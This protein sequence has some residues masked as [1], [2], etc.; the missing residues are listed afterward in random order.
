M[1]KKRIGDLLIEAGI[2]S[3]EQLKRALELQKQSGDRLGRI[4]ID[5]NFVSE[6]QI[7][8]VLE[9]QLGIPF[10]DLNEIEIPPDVQRL[11]PFQL[12]YRHNVVPVKVERTLL[13]VAMEDPLNFIAIEDLR[14]ATNYEIVPVISFSDAIKRTINRLYGSQTADK[15]IQEFQQEKEKSSISS[16]NLQNISS[17]EVDSAPIVRLV[18]STI[19]QAALSGASDIHIEPLENE[20]RV[21]FRVDGRL[22]L[23]QTIPKEAQSAV[24]TRVKIL[25]GLDIAEKRI[26]QD[27]RCDYRFKDKILNLRI[28]VLPTVHGEKI[29]MRIL[30]K[31][32]FLIPKE[33]LGFTQENLAK[34][35]ELLKNPHGIIL[36]TGPTGSGKSTT[37]YT[38]LSEL[39]KV[40]D[41]IMTVEDPVEYMIDGLNQVQVNAKAGLTFAGAL[42]AFLRQDPDIIMLGEIRDSETVEVAIRAAITGHLVLST[43]H[44]NDAV[45]SISRLIDMGVPPYMIAVSLMGIISQRLVRRLCTHCAESYIPPEHEVRFLGLPPGDYY[46]RKPVGC[47]L[48]NDTGYKGRIAVHEI[49]IVTKDMRDMIAAN[50]SNNALQEYAI[51]NGMTTLKQESIRLIL[52]GIT[53]FNEVMDIT[54]SI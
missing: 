29:V 25:C 34:F 49:L 47:A 3:E 26:P 54:F 38:M 15:A 16:Q 20:V 42:R 1:N 5:N 52:D 11:I 10:I 14:M 37:L 30:D 33:K 46:F 45:S 17:L 43:L 27:G 19:E 35:D 41:N 8:E 12:I 36:V 7:M 2:I 51:N 32:N 22:Q 31:T 44:T 21:R 18:N 9:F 6:T 53:S 13:Y 39:N 24:V 48:C 28:S 4:L 40:T 23:T 50:M